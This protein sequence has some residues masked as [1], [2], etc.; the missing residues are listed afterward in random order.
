MKTPALSPTVYS[1]GLYSPD[2]GLP[3]TS[4]RPNW[5]LR[6]LLSRYESEKVFAG[7]IAPGRIADGSLERRGVLFSEM[8]RLFASTCPSPCWSPGLK[9]TGEMRRQA[10]IYLPIAEIRPALH[11][12]VRLSLSGDHP[13]PPLLESAGSW[14]DLL[15]NLP[16]QIAC[17][18]PGR[19]VARMLKDDAARSIFL[20]SCYL[21]ER[22]GGDFGRY[23]G[24]SEFIREWAV[25]SAGRW[26]RRLSCLD[27]AC[28]T[29]EGLYELAKILLASGIPPGDI[30]ITGV[31]ISP[32]EVYAAASGNFP[33]LPWRKAAF[34]DFVRPLAETGA[35]AGCRFIADDLKTW[36]PPER[37]HLI[38]CNGL[39]GG[40]LMHDRD[41]VSRVVAKLAGSLHAGGAL[42]AA[43]RFHGGWKKLVSPSDLGQILAARGLSPLS[44]AEGVGGIWG[45]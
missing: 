19:F 15:E 12:L 40:P 31:T 9:L 36:E 32:L 1:S 29:G 44:I 30:R 45:G 10:E 42:L 7:L 38:V 3:A 18:N 20:F 35:L 11:R 26:G 28:G 8:F 25:S 14:L 39:L 34:G 21:P 13:A 22:F 17:I 16:S 5:S 37:Y 6:P 27:A 23:P 24:Q 41:A 33:H 2:I 4:N 43:D